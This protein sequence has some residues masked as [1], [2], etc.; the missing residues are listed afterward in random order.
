M[1]TLTSR[2]VCTLAQVTLFLH[3][4][5]AAWYGEQG[6]SRNAPDLLAGSETLQKLPTCSNWN[7]SL[8]VF[9]LCVTALDGYSHTHP[10]GDMMALIRLPGT[11]VHDPA[12]MHF[13]FPTQ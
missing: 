8:R 6:S 5:S 10:T 3:V 9:N 2:G 12:H 13:R 11:V 1:N 4:P 7:E